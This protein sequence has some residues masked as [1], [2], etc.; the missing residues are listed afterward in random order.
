MKLRII[1]STIAFLAFFSIS[2]GAVLFFNSLRDKAYDEAG[3]SAEEL[4]NDIAHNIDLHIREYSG[5]LAFISRQEEFRKALEIDDAETLLRANSQ[6][7][8]LCSIMENMDVCYLMDVNGNTIA[9]SN[10]NSP[11]SFVGKNY[12]FRPYFRQAVSG[13]PAEYAALGVTS[14]KRGLY[15]AYPVYSG[16]VERPSGVIVIKENIEHLRAIIVK[17]YEGV[18]M[19]TGSNGVVFFSNREGWLYKTLWEVT[20][21][22]TQEIK[23]SK[24]FGEGPW[25]WSGIKRTEDHHA[26]NTAGTEY[27]IHQKELR[28]MPG[29]NIVYLHDHKKVI[30]SNVETVLKRTGFLFMSISIFFGLVI[31][32]LLRTAS[33]DLSMRKKAVE[34][35]KKSEEN[36]NFY[37]TLIDQSNDSIEVLDPETGN[38]LNVNKKTC[39]DL[40]YSR[41]ELLSMKVFDIDPVVKPADFPKIMESLRE[42]D[43]SIWNGIHLRKD[44]SVFP[45]EVSLKLV[46]LDRDYLVAVARDITERKKN[47]E[48]LFESEKLYADLFNGMLEGFALHKIICDE[49]GRPVDYRFM[50]INP[51][52]ERL[53][54]LRAADLI[55]RTVLEVLPNT[56]P[57]WIETYGRVALTGEPIHFSNFSSELDKYFRVMAYSPRHEQFVAIFEDITERKKAEKERDRLNE[58]IKER[59]KELQQIVYTVSHDLRSPLVNIQGYS[60]MLALYLEKVMAVFRDEGAAKEDKEKAAS[61]VEKDIP[62]SVSY[63]IASVSKMD[64]MLSALLKLSRSVR[65]ELKIEELDMN[66]LLSD[67]LNAVDFQIKEAG[68]KIEASPL[69]SC[70]GDSVQINQV[71]S[72]L[73]SNALKYLSPERSGVIQ[74]TGNKND[75][76]TVYCVED[77]GIGIPAEE[78]EKI[79]EIFYRLDTEDVSGEG[80]GLAIVSKIIERHAGRIWAESEVGKGSKF[81]VKLPCT[82]FRS[83]AQSSEARHKVSK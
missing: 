37:Q 26:V 65:A 27:H 80:I 17:P 48:A 56:E 36:L 50:K 63:I 15:Y 13:V 46:R 81:F 39:T 23:E 44:G 40:G 38:F 7:D 58:Q 49:Q 62:E 67:V 54:G 20:P 79:F 30:S 34:E 16:K 78:I 60:R 24:Q 77:N 22:Q 4:V 11:D 41:E 5:I 53:T 76:K 19:M 31:L 55:G 45:V 28:N 47:E 74:V 61:I 9:S 66:K 52:F 72:N 12:S 43:A 10:R 3:K 73:I 18:M 33:L 69:P 57:F 6:L 64:S 83:K 2:L 35:L 1:I 25:E 75:G 29:W 32:Y 14:K 8:H 82:K 70:S 59:N 68:V 21:G 51:A 42:T 71:F